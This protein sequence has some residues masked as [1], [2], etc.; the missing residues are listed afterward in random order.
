MARVT[1][2]QGGGYDGGLPDDEPIPVELLSIDVVEDQRFD[3]GPRFALKWQTVDGNDIWI[4]DWLSVRLG[5]QQSG[6]V[7]KLRGLVNALHGRKATDEVAWADDETAEYGLDGEDTTGRIEPGIRV[8]VIGQNVVKDD[9]STVFRVEKYRPLPA[10]RGSNG[11]GSAGAR[12]PAPAASS[13]PA[14]RQPQP[15]G[16]PA[17]F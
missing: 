15:A 17:D 12:R 16:D 6:Q 8:A 2:P 3:A 9:G 11:N 14:Q 1:P 5:K 10:Q 4:R 13:R 7:S